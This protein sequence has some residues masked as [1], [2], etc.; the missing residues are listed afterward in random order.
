MAGKVEFRKMPIVR[1]SVVVA[2]VVGGLQA[3]L[4]GLESQY[5]GGLPLGE[6]LLSWHTIDMI[7]GWLI[8]ALA[9]AGVLGAVDY[10]RF[11][12]SRRR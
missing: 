8:T 10:S 11:K 4:I 2:A 7:F 5:P 6:T 9:S 3:L 12:H 1:A